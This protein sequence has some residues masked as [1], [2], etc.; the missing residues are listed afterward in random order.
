MPAGRLSAAAARLDGTVLHPGDSLSL[1]DRLGAALPDGQAAD[2]LATATFNAAW[3]GG[4]R[5]ASHATHATYP[6]QGSTA[7][8]LGR[9]ATLRQG[10]D[11]AFLD[12]TRY[13]VL[14][15]VAFDAPAARRAGSL[16]VTL[17]STP[18]WTV[19]SAHD[20]P[21]DV[22]PAG[23]VVGH[24]RGCVAQRRRRR[25]PGHRHPHLGAA[26]LGRGR[27][28]RLL[29]R[30]LPTAAGGRLPLTRCPAG[31]PMPAVR[32]SSWSRSCAASSTCLCRHSEAR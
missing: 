18:R 19:T 9:D 27:P 3:L 13:G 17:W 2:A 7:G 23:R 14:V 31:Q 12:D 28:Q 25:V 20:T 29:H 22:V 1:R 4:L 6:G 32:S 21:T 10:Q 15:S 30:S 5:I 24:G 16:T 26:G 8:P 11:L